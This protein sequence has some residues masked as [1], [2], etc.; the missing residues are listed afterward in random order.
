VVNIAAAEPFA[1]ADLALKAKVSCSSNCDLRG[2]TIRIADDK[3]AIVKEIEL[4]SFDEATNETDEFV[5]KAPV[6]PG[7][8][9]W[10]A[11]FAAQQKEGI[12]H[13]ETSVPF[14]FVVKPH[15]TSMAVWDVPSPI[16]SNAKFK[17]KVGVTCSAGCKLTGREIEIYDHAGARAATDTLGGVPWSDAGALYWAEVELQAPGK[18]GYYTWEAKFLK[19]DLE[20]PHEGASHAFVFGTGRQPE[21]VVTI[22]VLDIDTKAPIKHADV[23]LHPYRDHSDELG[24]ARLAVPNGE[25]ELYVTATDKQTFRTTVKVA[26]DVAIR[27]ELLVAPVEDTG[28]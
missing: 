28:G 9:R 27:A 4:V 20:L 8:Y 23:I 12:S 1:G 10:K 3:G 21:H 26:S 7:E 5:V 16:V 24:M 25:Y 18:E 11:V 22:Q 15:T 2:A 19:P 6:K 14:S 13:E 17:L